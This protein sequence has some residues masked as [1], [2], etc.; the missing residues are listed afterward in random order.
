MKLHG[1]PPPVEL[2]RI[3]IRKKGHKYTYLAFEETTVEE[4]VAFVQDV[5]KDCLKHD[6]FLKGSRVAAD[7]RH[8][9]GKKAGRSKTVSFESNITPAELRELLLTEFQKRLKK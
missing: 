6:P 2:I 3:H 5:V 7:V 9:I 8:F 4:V 1:P